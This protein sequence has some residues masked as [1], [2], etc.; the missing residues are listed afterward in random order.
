MGQD[1]IAAGS[2]AHDRNRKGRAPRDRI[3]T[4]LAGRPAQGRLE[5]PSI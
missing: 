1:A 5:Q 4:S 2:A 3:G